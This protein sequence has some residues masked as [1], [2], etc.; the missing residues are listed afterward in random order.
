MVRLK[1]LRFCQDCRQGRQ[2]TRP[3]AFHGVLAVG[4]SPKTQVSLKVHL[5]GKEGWGAGDVVPRAI[6]SLLLELLP[7]L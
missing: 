4:T 3:Q 1:G 6:Y 7:L 2:N 5:F